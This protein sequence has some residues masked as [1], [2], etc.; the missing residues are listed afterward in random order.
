MNFIEVA[1]RGGGR[2][3][4]RWDSI[5]AVV[6]IFETPGDAKS[7]RIAHTLQLQLGASNHIVVEGESME[8]LFTKMTVAGGKGQIM[9]VDDRAA[10]IERSAAA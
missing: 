4:V 1:R 7:R 6:E 5:T 2:V 9:V 8:S 3:R 10:G